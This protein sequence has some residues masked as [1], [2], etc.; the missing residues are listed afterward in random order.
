VDR[1][2]A[3]VLQHSPRLTRV[4]YLR[5]TLPPD[6]YIRSGVTGWDG[7]RLGIT[8]QELSRIALDTDPRVALAR[9]GGDR[10]GNMA[11]YAAVVAYQMQPGDEKVVAERL[12]ALLSKPPKAAAPSAPSGA[13]ISVAGQWEAQLDIT[14]ANRR[15]GADGS[16]RRD[17]GRS[18]KHQAVC[19]SLFND[20]A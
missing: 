18:G 15:D 19:K 12:F 13:A 4:I 14:G 2:P 8:G 17:A 5:D 3:R 11:S 20:I 7:A 9:A 6:C 16:L 1:Q 10:S